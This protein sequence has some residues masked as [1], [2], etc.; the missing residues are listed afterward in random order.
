M[1]KFSRAAQDGT[2]Q[3]TLEQ[4]AEHLDLPVSDALRDMFD[5][6]DRVS[7]VWGVWGIGISARGLS[8]WLDS[9]GMRPR[10]IVIYIF[11]E[12]STH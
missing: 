1:E 7:W 6:Y 10:E 11:H 9:S 8:L 2:G 5:L 4:F 3:V 12:C